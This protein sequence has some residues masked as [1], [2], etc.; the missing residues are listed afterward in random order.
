MVVETH[1]GSLCSEVSE[2]G[3]WMN[4][5]EVDRRMGKIVPEQRFQ[6]SC[7]D[8][9]LIDIVEVGEVGID[10][11]DPVRPAEDDG[12]DVGLGDS[13]G[14]ERTVLHPGDHVVQGPGDVQ[15]DR[16]DGEVPTV[17]RLVKEDESTVA[18]G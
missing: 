7:G 12:H 1:Q 2:P 6:R 16:C 9:D 18:H 8:K 17:G 10:F 14:E 11:N 15:S 5:D 13:A 3:E 4:L